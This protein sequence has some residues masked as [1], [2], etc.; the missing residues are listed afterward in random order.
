MKNINFCLIAGMVF[1]SCQKDQSAPMLAADQN[2]SS[3]VTTL[4]TVPITAVSFPKEVICVDGG[5]IEFW[6]KLNGYGG[7]I[8]VGGREAHFFQ[9][10]DGSSTFHMG[11]NAN[12]GVAN[13]GLAGV[14]GASFHCGTGSFGTWTYENIYG[15]GNVN[16]WHHYVFVWDKNG[17]RCL[18]DVNKK[19]AIYIDGV[20]NTTS[21]H[22][23]NQQK[24]LPLTAGV[25]NL[26][27]TGNPPLVQGGEVAIDELKIYDR[28]G[29]LI[30]WNTLGSA[31][32]IANSEIGPNGS[33]NGGGNAHFVPGKSGNAVTA[34]PVHGIGNL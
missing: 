9:V 13:G 27:T 21:W 5:K 14:A 24:F 22:A 1:I 10:H 25:F 29:K 17:L 16:K 15:A 8:S 30:L 11:F 32:E 4:Q 6:A 34:I 20:L 33:F 19:L 3:I 18:N 2:E 28:R 12:D 23:T 7:Q 26:I 31:D